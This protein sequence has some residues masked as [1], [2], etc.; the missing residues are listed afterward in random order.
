MLF[1]QQRPDGGKSGVGAL[2]FVD[3]VG[4]R[5]SA[6]TLQFAGREFGKKAAGFEAQ[7]FAPFIGVF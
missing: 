4:H 5:I 3:T 1:R 2:F 7:A 6:V